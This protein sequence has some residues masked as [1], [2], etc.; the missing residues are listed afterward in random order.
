M[1]ACS[2]DLGFHPWP[3]DSHTP[4]V[5]PQEKWTRMHVFVLMPILFIRLSSF[6][7]TVGPVNCLCE[8][9]GAACSVR[10]A[11]QSRIG[12]GAFLLPKSAF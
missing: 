10:S 4:R 12:A 5:W 8:R 9:R 11:A 7:E 6:W 1:H 2:S 3:R